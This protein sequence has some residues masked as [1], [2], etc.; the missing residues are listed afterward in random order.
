M[1]LVANASAPITWHNDVSAEFG[2]RSTVVVPLTPPAGR[3]FG[4]L[5]LG[6]GRRRS[7]SSQELFLLQS[8][9]GEFSWIVRDLGARAQRQGELVTVS[10]DDVEVIVKGMESNRVADRLRSLFEPASRLEGARDKSVGG[11]TQ[12]RKYL[13]NAGGDGYLKSCPEEDAEFIVRVPMES[14]LKSGRAKFR[15]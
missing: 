13:D 11:L 14:S 10:H 9:A 6:D 2:Y 7:Y 1:D 8:L 12:V 5:M 3:S 15:S 4:F